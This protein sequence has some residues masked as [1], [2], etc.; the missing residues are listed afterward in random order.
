MNNTDSESVR[1]GRR[2]D[3]DWLRVVAM[4]AVFL[5]HCA[6]FFNEMDWHLK[7]AEQSFFASVFTGLLDMWMMHLFFLL[8]GVASWYALRSRSG[9][10]YLVDRVKRLLIPLYTVGMIVLIP[11]QLYYELVS[12]QGY[13][14]TF[15]ELIQLYVETAISSGIRFGSPFFVNIFYGHLWFLQFL[16]IISLVTLPLLLYLRSEGGRSA[17]E[18]LAGF[19]DRWGGIYL[20]LIPLFIVAISLRGIFVGEHTWADLVYFML[21]F[22]AGYIIPADQRFTQAFKRHCWVSLALGIVGFGGVAFFVAG[23]GYDP[24][25]ESFSGSFVMFQ[26]A[27]SIANWG[28]VAFL[29]SVGA[30]HLNFNNKVLAYSNEALLPF[31][32]FHQTIILTVGWFVIPLDMGILPKFIIITVVSFVAIMVLY[33]LLVRRFN[34]V[35]FFFGMRPKKKLPEATA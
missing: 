6:R 27:F 23:Q 5:F 25:G 14:G 13:T 26:I 35:R 17:I 24:V 19:C 9:G 29:L 31:Y 34:V 20:F 33:E 16:F 22:L 28:W 30:K 3:V 4:G 11:P 21:F 15:W 12:H 8:A 7:N 2:Y 10:Q 32:I 1:P 18:R